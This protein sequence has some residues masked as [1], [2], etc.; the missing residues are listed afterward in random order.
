MVAV[1]GVYSGNVPGYMFIL[2]VNSPFLLM[3]L[4]KEGPFLWA[5]YDE[6]GFFEEMM[7]AIKP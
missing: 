7:E 6:V 5:L 3:F 4:R 2:C 1:Q